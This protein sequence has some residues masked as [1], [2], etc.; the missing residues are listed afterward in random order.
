MSLVP[1]EDPSEY[2]DSEAWLVSQLLHCAARD[3]NNLPK[4]VKDTYE[5]GRVLF[6]P[7]RIEIQTSKGILEAG[8]EDMLIR[9]TDGE[10]AVIKK[11]GQ[12]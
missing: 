11:R 9:G 6:L 3:W 12:R 1:F 4:S 8:I 2:E 10:F 5:A 7:N